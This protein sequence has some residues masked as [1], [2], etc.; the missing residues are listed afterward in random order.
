MLRGQENEKAI[1]KIENYLDV[2]LAGLGGYHKLASQY[3]DQEIFEVLKMAKQ[4]R[5]KNND[6]KVHQKLAAGVEQ[7]FDIVK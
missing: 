4:Y 3:P 2:T 1:N 5:Q 7:A 6:H